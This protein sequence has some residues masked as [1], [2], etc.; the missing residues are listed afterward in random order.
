ML[1]GSAAQVLALEPNGDRLAGSFV[2]VIGPHPSGSDVDVEVRAF[3]PGSQG[4]VE[5]PVTGSLNAAI[6]QWLIESGRVTDRYVAAQGTALGR[7]GRVHIERAGDDVWVGG[8][9]VP[10]V[11]GTAS[12]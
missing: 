12:I 11:E 8:N 10:V 1:L 4:M 6:G 3:F 5:D 9:C 2:G 7:A